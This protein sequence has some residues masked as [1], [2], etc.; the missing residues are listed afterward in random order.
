MQSR[1]PALALQL[2]NMEVGL[3]GYLVAAIWGSYGWLVPTYIYLALMHV[4]ARLLVEH[5]ELLEPMVGR[6]RL[7]L[8]PAAAI[9]TASVGA[10]A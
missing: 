9:A 7:S 3:Y 4:G 8:A 2:F 10:R 5:G 1:A 6:R